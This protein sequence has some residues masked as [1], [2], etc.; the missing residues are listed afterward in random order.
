MEALIFVLFL[1]L[2][3]GV[4]FLLVVL[5][6]GHKDKIKNK[7]KK[8]NLEKESSLIKEE[9]KKSV[10]KNSKNQSLWRETVIKNLTTITVICLFFYTITFS[11]LGHDKNQL[12]IW[13]IDGALPIGFV[14]VIFAALNTKPKKGEIKLW[15]YR[16][17]IGY[18]TYLRL[19]AYC[20]IYSAVVGLGAVLLA[21]Y[22]YPSWSAVLKDV[23]ILSSFIG[24]SWSLI[25]LFFFALQMIFIVIGKETKKSKKTKKKTNH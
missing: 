17:Y 3:F 11:A 19:I 10:K 21:P 4:G 7:N 9:K 23:F 2:C 12:I 8:T 6:D 1:I 5:E 15:F 25:F 22:Q 14:C 24:L 20:L 13:V 18:T 16:C